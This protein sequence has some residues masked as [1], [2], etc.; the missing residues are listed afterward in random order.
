MFHGEIN[1]EKTS[2][3]VTKQELD[4][5]R[6]GIVKLCAGESWTILTSMLRKT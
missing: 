2:S 1:N 4:N 6:D 3:V 5:P